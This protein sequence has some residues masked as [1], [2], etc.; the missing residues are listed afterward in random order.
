MDTQQRRI[1]GYLAQNE[2]Y[3][4]LDALNAIANLPLEPDGSKHSPLRG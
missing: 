3:R 2:D 4:S 1:P